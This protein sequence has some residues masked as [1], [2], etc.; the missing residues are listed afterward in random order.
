MYIYV[1]KISCI[2]QILSVQLNMDFFFN[3]SHYQCKVDKFKVLEKKDEQN[4]TQ[5]RVLQCSCDCYME[6]WNTKSFHCY[7]LFQIKS[8]HEGATHM[9]WTELVYFW[10]CCCYTDH[11]WLIPSFPDSWLIFTITRDSLLLNNYRF[12][13]LFPYWFYTEDNHDLFHS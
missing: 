10:F 3:V 1:Y 7:V 4:L 11:I 12:L 13:L 5:S 8:T 9:L 2:V 6:F